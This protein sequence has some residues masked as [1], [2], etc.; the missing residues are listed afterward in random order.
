MLGVPTGLARALDRDAVNDPALHEVL[1]AFADVISPWTV[2]PLPQHPPTLPG[3][4]R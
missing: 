1:I 3:V 2:G 4:M